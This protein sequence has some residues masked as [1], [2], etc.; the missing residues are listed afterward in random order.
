MCR[1]GRHRRCL[2]RVQRSRHGTSPHHRRHKAHRRLV[3]CPSGRCHTR[4]ECKSCGRLPTQISP[5]RKTRKACSRGQY[6]PSLCR[7]STADISQCWRLRSQSAQS[8]RRT[9]SS[10]RSSLGPP[11]FGACQLHMRCKA[12]PR[13]HVLPCAIP[14]CRL[15]KCQTLQCHSSCAQSQQRSYRS[16]C[17]TSGLPPPGTGQQSTPRSA[18]H[19][20]GSCQSDRIYRRCTVRTANPSFERRWP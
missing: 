4:T 15:R 14:L 2:P 13:S 5:P 3:P 18:K 16:S 1:I 9:A 11:A 12:K 7:W 6:Q 10:S 20:S 8:R 19:P 17:T